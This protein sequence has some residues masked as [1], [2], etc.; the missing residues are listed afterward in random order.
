MPDPSPDPLPRNTSLLIE[1]LQDD[2]VWAESAA[3]QEKAIDICHYAFKVAKKPPFIKQD[4]LV[5]VC[6]TLSDDATIKELNKNYRNKDKPTNVLSFPQYTSDD[7]FFPPQEGEPLMMGDII[8][9]YETMVS[10]AA[11]QSKTVENHTLH[12]ILH[13]FLHLLEYDHIDE[14]EAEDM[15]AMEVA[16]LSH[17]NI[18]N[19]Y[20]EDLDIKKLV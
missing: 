3:F 5:E 8:L 12:L 20:A 18:P 11:E 2:G 15:E 10:E 1:I 16:I 6:I 17:F 7:T 9:A 13:G 14:E 4:Q 19:P